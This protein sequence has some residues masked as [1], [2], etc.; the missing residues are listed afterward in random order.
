M[1]KL[2][3]AGT[4]SL[5]RYGLQHHLFEEHAAQAALLLEEATAAE[6]RSPLSR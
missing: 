5:V 6:M 4:A 3:V 1:E 2:G